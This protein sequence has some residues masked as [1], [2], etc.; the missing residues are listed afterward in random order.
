M[1]SLIVIIATL[2]ATCCILSLGGIT[3][4]VNV[5]WD[6]F[7]AGQENRTLPI[8]SA[9]MTSASFPIALDSKTPKSLV[10]SIETKGN[11]VT[12]KLIFKVR[13]NH[14][15]LI[16]GDRVES[17]HSK[18]AQCKSVS[19]T[20]FVCQTLLTTS[21]KPT[22]R[23]FFYTEHTLPVTIEAIE[24]QVARMKR[25][26]VLGGNIFFAYILILASLGPIFVYLQRWEILGK[27]TLIATSSLFCLYLS[28]YSFLLIV[29]FLLGAFFLITALSQKIINPRGCLLIIISYSIL[30]LLFVK[31]FLP[32]IGHIFANPG[33]FWFLL[34]LGF[35]YFIIRL[36]DV[37]VS[38]YSGA[39]NKVTLIDFLSFMLFPATLAAGPIFTWNA[40]H[41]GKIKG[42]NSIDYASGIA[43]IFIGILKKILADA[44]IYPFVLNQSNSFILFP[45]SMADGSILGFLMVNTLFV[46]LDFSAYSDM[47]I[48]AGRSMGWNVPEN[49]NFPLFKCSLRRFWQSWH[50]T[51]S[52]WVM[53][54]VYMSA[55]MSSRSITLST[56]ISMLTIGLWHSMSL[57]W[58]FW[59][60]HHSAILSLERIVGAKSKMFAGRISRTSSEFGKKLF[61]FS[62]VLLVWFWVSLGHSFTLFSNFDLATHAYLSALQAPYW[63][64]LN[65]ITL[66]Y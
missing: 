52:N 15:T 10:A 50:M 40:F 30:F 16:H 63:S 13:G 32:Q 49:F 8:Q 31:I 55:V 64:L 2:L 47:A 20:K 3:T 7:N 1:R 54:R 48:G 33:R 34:P 6:T 14:V 24:F 65:L 18:S 56:F 57:S 61:Y 19:D 9:D 22:D 46:Y 59:A 39:V 12:G 17:F 36:I 66:E 37:S 41:S 35:S 5:K 4:S 23:V 45:D 60:L 62:G 27:T 11:V 21:S 26:N 44:F 53:R 25:I 58:T 28:S 51:L 38:V 42:Y 29:V 43:R